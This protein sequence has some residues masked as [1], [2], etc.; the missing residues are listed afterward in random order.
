MNK[1][2]QLLV[3]QYVDSVKELNKRCRELSDHRRKM[4]I[5][6]KYLNILK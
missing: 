6:K 5:T 3:K 2:Y 4:E 1:I